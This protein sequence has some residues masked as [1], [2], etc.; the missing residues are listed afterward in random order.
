LLL[1]RLIDE[2]VIPKDP[3]VVTNLAILVGLLAHRRCWL[4]YVGPL[5]FITNR[6]RSYL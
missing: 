1:K 2:G 3:S 6:R 5:F 4:Q